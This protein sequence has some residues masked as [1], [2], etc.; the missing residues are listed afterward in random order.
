MSQPLVALVNDGVV[1]SVIVATM[2]VIQVLDSMGVWPAGQVEIDVTATDP[3][4]GIGWTYDGSTFTP[5]PE[6]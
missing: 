6:P 1:T 2:D 5:P 3:T 4:P